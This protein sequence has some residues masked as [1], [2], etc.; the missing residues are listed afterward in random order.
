MMK[1]YANAPV[2]VLTPSNSTGLKIARPL[3]MILTRKSFS[4]RRVA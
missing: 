2:L 3:R 1:N 4:E